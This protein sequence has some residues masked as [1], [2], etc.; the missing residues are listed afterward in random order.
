MSASGDRSL[1]LGKN[2]S[3]A[4]GITAAIPLPRGMHCEVRRSKSKD[5]AT[6]SGERTVVFI[7]VDEAADPGCVVADLR[8]LLRPAEFDALVDAA[9]RHPGTPPGIASVLGSI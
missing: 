1:G 6:V 9:L 8:R 7:V 4:L 3:V 5:S 2:G